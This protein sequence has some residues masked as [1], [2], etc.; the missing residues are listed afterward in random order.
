MNQGMG[1]FFFVLLS[2]AGPLMAQPKVESSGITATV[3]LEEVVF[4]HLSELNGKF[5]VRATEAM[6]APGAYLGVHHHVGPGIRY[7]VSGTLTFTE[8]GKATIYRA[9]DYF[10]ESGNIAH[11]AQNNT[12][13]PLRIIFFEVLPAHWTGPT[14]IG[15]KSY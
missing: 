10:Y 8:G 5:K 7:V 12:K 4:G 3:K 6:F 13:S 15:P 11:T 2:G 1:I 9:G 14:V